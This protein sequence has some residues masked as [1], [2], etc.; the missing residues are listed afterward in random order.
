MN[1]HLEISSPL[2]MTIEKGFVRHASEMLRRA[3]VPFEIED[4]PCP[5][6]RLIDVSDAEIR[7]VIRVLERQGYIVKVDKKDSF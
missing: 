6:I 1:T 3:Q 2:R 4:G 5:L 7:Y